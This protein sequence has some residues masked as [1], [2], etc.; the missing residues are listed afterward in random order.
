ML[1]DQDLMSKVVHSSI[2]RQ[3]HW[4]VQ[5]FVLTFILLFYFTANLSTSSVIFL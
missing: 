3:L 1:E 5:D 4:P 2:I